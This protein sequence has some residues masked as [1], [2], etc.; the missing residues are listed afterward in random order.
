[1]QGLTVEEKT[2][3]TKMIMNLLDSWEIN[4]EGIMNILSLPRG[5]RVRALRRYRDDTP[6]PDD[7]NTD[8]RIEHL[9]GIAEALYTTFPRNAHMRAQWM[10]QPHKRFNGKS[11]VSIMIEDGLNGIINVRAQLDC[12]FAWRQSG[13]MK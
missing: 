4:G 7:V 13:A 12:T 5:T 6:F 11:P 3:L 2:E 8:T 10:N 1:M 9:V